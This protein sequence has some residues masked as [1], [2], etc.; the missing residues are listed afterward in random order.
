MSTKTRPSKNLHLATVANPRKT[1]VRLVHN[2][3]VVHVQLDGAQFEAPQDVF[4][5]DYVDAVPRTDGVSLLFAKGHPI[6]RAALGLVEIFI[7]WSM[8]ID[9]VWASIEESFQTGLANHVAKTFPKWAPDEI[10]ALEA[11][12]CSSRL[13]SLAAI[14]YTQ[15]E[16]E[17]DFHRIATGDLSRAIRG[18]GD[19]VAVDPVVRVLLSVS[20]LHHL[21]KRCGELV[22]TRKAGVAS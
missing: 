18:Q 13:A 8:F 7:P 19:G 14:S 16:A 4:L 20:L 2:K 22:A 5:A 15:D 3:D 1:P 12:R 17:I 9:G 10:H 21:I 11:A 6:S